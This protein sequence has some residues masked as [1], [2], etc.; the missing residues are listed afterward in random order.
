MGTA[1][2][3]LLQLCSLI[4]QLPGAVTQRCR[5][6]PVPRYLRNFFS[7]FYKTPTDTK[8]QSGCWDSEARAQAAASHSLFAALQSLV[9]LHPSSA[10]VLG[11]STGERTLTQMGWELSVKKEAAEERQKEAGLSP[12]CHWD[13]AR[14]SETPRLSA[15]KE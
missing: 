11:Q 8:A 6:L 9:C 5:F 4:A 1:S 12:A 15:N 14:Y 2:L 10:S 13:S 3:V 7:P